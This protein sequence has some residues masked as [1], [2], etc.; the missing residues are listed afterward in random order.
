VP[1]APRPLRCRDV[2]GQEVLIGLFDSAEAAGAAYRDRTVAATGVATGAGDCA[3]GP[4]REH[5][6]PG[7]GTPVG[8]VLCGRDASTAGLTWIDTPARTVAV[9]VRPDGNA[10]ELYRSWATWVQVPAFPAPQEQELLALLPDTDC[11]RAPAGTLEGLDGVVVALDCV[12]TDA[13]AGTVTY[14]RFADAE[15]LRRSYAAGV[16]E[17]GAQAGVDCLNAATPE[18]LGDTAW[19]AVRSGPLGRV[20]CRPDDGGRPSLTWTAD[21]LLVLA[22]AMGT[23]PAGLRTFWDSGFRPKLLEMVKVLNERAQPPFPSAEESALLARIPAASS[24]A[25]LRPSSDAVRDHVGDAAVVA[26]VCGTI[27]GPDAYYYQYADPAA[28]TAAIGGRAR[29]PDCTTNPP[30]FRGAAQYTRPDGSTGTLMCGRNDAGN[31][32]LDWTDDAKRIR[33]LA[34]AVEPA[35]LIAWWQTDAG[36]R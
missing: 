2:A 17:A 30:D 13:G 10:L 3:D 23:D 9:A 26:V 18:F 29:G 8:R 33:A 15:S 5:V 1:G 24:V 27:R 4:G 12:P 11:R 34:F 14:F 22:R 31:A 28:L 19:G 32:V 21:P 25:C 7:V 16:S 36:P 35:T 6:Y 20:L